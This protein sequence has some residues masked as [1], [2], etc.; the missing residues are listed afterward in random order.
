MTAA[1]LAVLLRPKRK[2]LGCGT[3]SMMNRSSTED[4]DVVVLTHDDKKR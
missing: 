4:V 3:F 2:P 1:Y